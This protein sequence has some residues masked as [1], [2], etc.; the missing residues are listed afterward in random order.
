MAAKFTIPG[1]TYIG[2]GALAAAGSDICALGTKALIVT[3]QSMIKQGF[4]KV[5]TDILE[6]NGVGYVID[7]QISGEP[8]DVMIEEGLLLYQENACD[9]I[10]GFGGGSPLD[11]AKAIG[12]MPTASRR[13]P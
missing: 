6:Q 4:M 13:M 1:T 7:S 9:F 10:I 2:D 11:S 8:T 12:A 5:L 3:G